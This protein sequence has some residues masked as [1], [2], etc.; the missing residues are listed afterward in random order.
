MKSEAQLKAEIKRLQQSVKAQALELE[1]KNR[2][3]EIEAALE[4]VRNRTLLMKD[5]AEL[6]ETVSIFF[7]SLIY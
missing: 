4:R 5:S 1:S 3:L 6:N 7:S 2:E